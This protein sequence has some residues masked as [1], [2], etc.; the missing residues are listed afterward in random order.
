MQA[1]SNA[2]ETNQTTNPNTLKHTQLTTF[3]K[4]PKVSKPPTQLVT[5]KPQKST[6]IQLIPE[7][8]HTV[9]INKTQIIKTQIN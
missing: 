4:V 6:K 5:N 9:N 8:K 3:N 7:T 2:I 1:I